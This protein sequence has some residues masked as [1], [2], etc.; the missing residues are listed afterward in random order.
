MGPGKQCELGGGGFR[1][2]PHSARVFSVLYI[3]EKKPQTGSALSPSA[4][5]GLNSS[6]VPHLRLSD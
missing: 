5:Q 6:Q 1:T 4:K 3:L 2:T